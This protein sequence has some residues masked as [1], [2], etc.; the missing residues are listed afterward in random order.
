MPP[1]PCWLCTM[2]GEPAGQSMHAFIV[3]K[4]GVMEL[5]CIAQQVSDY[6]LLQHE[7]AVGV[8]ANDVYAHIVEHSLHPRVRLAVLLRQLLDLTSLVQNSIV[9]QDGVHCTVDKANAELYLKIIGQIMALYKVDT[10]SMLFASEEESSM[11][12]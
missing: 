1:T 11:A 9:V 5:R 4:I 2:H 6:V 10:S 8:G 7:D 3:A 12:T